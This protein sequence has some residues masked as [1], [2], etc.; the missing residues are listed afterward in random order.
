MSPPNLIPFLSSED[1]DLNRFSTQTPLILGHV[2]LPTADID[3]EAAGICTF[4]DATN[5]LFM[6]ICQEQFSENFG[7]A[8]R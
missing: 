1:F 6:Y 8:F 4:R 2:I 7:T 3:I 5:A